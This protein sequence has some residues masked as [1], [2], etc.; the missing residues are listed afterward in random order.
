MDDVSRLPY[1]FSYIAWSLVHS[2]VLPSP[3]A[4]ACPPDRCAITFLLLFS[5]HLTLSDP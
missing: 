5:L 2:V 1:N 3:L 4:L